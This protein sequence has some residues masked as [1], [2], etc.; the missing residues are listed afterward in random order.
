MNIFT[1]LV[2]EEM[3]KCQIFWQS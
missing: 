1:D 2:P 3:F